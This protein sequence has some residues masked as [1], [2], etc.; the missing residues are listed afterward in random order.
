MRNS[1]SLTILASRYPVVAYLVAIAVAFAAPAL[2]AVSLSDTP[3]ERSAPV[4]NAAPVLSQPAG[5]A[6]AAG[7]MADQT[8]YATDSDGDPLTFTKWAGPA[9]MTVSTTDPGNGSGVGNV[10]LA[11]GL[12]ESG[13][14]TG[15]VAV[16][17]GA[18]TDLRSFSIDV[19]PT[20]MAPSLDQPSD[21]AVT[22]GTTATQE[23]RASDA[24]GDPLGF[25]LVS[26]PGF[27]SVNTI[28]PGV[29]TAI[30]ELVLSPGLSAG[31]ISIATVGVSD[32]SLTDQKSLTITVQ[33]VSVPP[34]LNQPSDM[35]ARV[36]EITN[37]ALFASDA[38]GGSLDFTL[39]AGPPYMTVTTVY[40]LAGIG[41]VRL[42]PGTGDIGTAVG[43]IQ[44]SDGELSDQKSFGI[45]VVSNRAPALAQIMDMTAQAGESVTQPLVATDADGDP[46]TFSKLSGPPYM[47]VTT[48]SPGS[49]IATGSVTISPSDGDVGTATATV[50]ASDGLLSDQRSFSVT[51]TPEPPPNLSCVSALRAD[52][53][54]GS[55]PRGI[56]TADLDGDGDLDIAV[57]NGQS[58]TCSVFRNLGA[59]HFE[60]AGEFSTGSY[61][62]SVDAADLNHDGMMDLVVGHFLGASV[63]LG[64]GDGTFH[65]APP[66]ETPSSISVRLADLNG[67]GHADI[68]AAGFDVNSAVIA[69]GR[70]DGTFGEPIRY[71]SFLHPLSI[72]VGDLNG[73]GHPDLVCGRDATSIGEQINSVPVLFGHGDGTFGEQLNV[74]TGYRPRHVALADLN[75]DGNNDL[76]AANYGNGSVS[77]I[78]GHGDGTFGP[79]LEL[80]AMGAV[81][82]LAVADF[83][84][85]SHLD[86]ATIDVQERGTVI[87]LLGDGDGSF[88][89]RDEIRV[90]SVPVTIAAAPLSGPGRA[91]L[92]VAN[93]AS[94]SASIL[95]VGPIVMSAGVDLT[96]HTINLGNHAPD[97]TVYLE[98][99][100]FDATSIDLSSVRLAGSVPPTATKSPTVGDHDGDGLPDL[101]LKFSRPLLDP[102]LIVG[103]NT[104]RVSGAL[105][106]GGHFEGE[107][108][109][110][111]LG[112]PKGETAAV[113][114]NPFKGV[115]TLSF[116]TTMAGHVRVRVFDLQGRLLRELLDD[117]NVP[118]GEHKVDLEGR[119]GR[120]V[121]H[122]SGVYFYRVEAPEGA[123]QGR[124]TVVK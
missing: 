73:D 65:P 109:V 23:L 46:V 70:G 9:F 11:P 80:S 92:V 56:A 33:S 96:P 99:R 16:F 102:L 89:C 105:Q 88:V 49:G 42:A 54:V 78:L 34:Y 52:Y 8:L 19:S 101:M 66:V 17:D 114:P 60:L 28:D 58:S 18:K 3:A 7:E 10:H 38:N 50:A 55:G 53:P 124:F 113:L 123:F 122:P 41:N 120:G 48:D 30:G 4:S 100:G 32:G 35:R 21:M 39:V 94:N 103:M 15:T 121:V 5:M 26:G 24:N 97:V 67:D 75:G 57:A 117:P 29:G 115:G 110:K 14:T 71:G 61:P 107:G 106:T 64:V 81:E 119:V 91:D 68:A 45:T 22:A 36:G 79:R 13:S 69:L 95:L 118:A 25:R 40:P 31:G 47:S 37:Q 108:V 72:A 12:S 93:E 83:N 84:L 90:G 111:V 76:I 44:V 86:L 77:M 112:K 6:L 2:A 87:L 1:G 63:H 98:P 27:A 43:R 62:Y 116:I 59:G 82:G 20:P 85:D 74:E 104:L 51:V